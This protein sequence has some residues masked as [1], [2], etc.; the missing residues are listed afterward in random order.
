MTE[1]QMRDAIRVVC[2]EALE[3]IGPNLKSLSWF[4]KNNV[5]KRVPEKVAA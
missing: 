5:T 2:W 1:T 4:Y 3:A